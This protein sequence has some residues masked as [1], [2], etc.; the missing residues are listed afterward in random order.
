MKLFR[1]LKFKS[2]V[3]TAVCTSLNL[4][5]FGLSEG[6]SADVS[7]SALVE[8]TLISALD[9]QS[10]TPVPDSSPACLLLA[11]Q[12]GLQVIRPAARLLLVQG[13]V[14][15]DVLRA[16]TVQFG[17]S[18]LKVRGELVLLTGPL[19]WQQSGDHAVLTAQFERGPFQ[20]FF[21][22]GTHTSTFLQFALFPN[23]LCLLE[24]AAPALEQR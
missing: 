19:V 14:Q 11:G 9:A 23:E 12:R 1:R 17:A 20:G 18:G 4:F 21:N 8:R 6:V 16:L 7:T 13:D 24:V 22:G 2:I 15:D 5:P 10:L 3:L